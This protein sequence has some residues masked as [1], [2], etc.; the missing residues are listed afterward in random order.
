MPLYFVDFNDGRTEARD[1]VGSEAPS[2]EAARDDVMRMLAETAKFAVAYGDE[3]LLVA[4]IRDGAGQELYRV[5]LAVTCSQLCQATSDT[6]PSAFSVQAAGL[7][8][9]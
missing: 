4:T 9:P 8:A 2:P 7:R 6:S 1:E 5:T 3:Q